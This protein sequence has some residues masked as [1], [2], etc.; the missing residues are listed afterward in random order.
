M[1]AENII[2]VVV[3]EG[4]E[5][6]TEADIGEWLKKI[7]D[8]VSVDEP[9]VSL[10]T[11]KAAMDV[12]APAAGVIVEVQGAEG[13]TVPVGALLARIETGG[14]VGASAGAGASAAPAAAPAASAGGGKMVEVVVPEGG[15]S[16][17]EADIGEWLKNVGDSV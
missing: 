17:T 2:D 8:H 12:A 14:D 3:P 11:D 4:G 15:E 5:S 7:G 9:I 10:E 16:V 13:D 1:A 6:V